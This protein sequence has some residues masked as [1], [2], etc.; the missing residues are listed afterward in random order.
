MC[1]NFRNNE[2]MQIMKHRFPPPK[3]MRLSPPTLRVLEEISE[4]LGN[5]GQREAFEIVVRFIEGLSDSTG[6]T[7]KSLLV[8]SELPELAKLSQIS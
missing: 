3:Y 5:V 1:I 7:Y 2:E 4:Q 8:K 6:L